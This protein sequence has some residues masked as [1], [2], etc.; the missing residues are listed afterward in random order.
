ME[1]K[2]EILNQLNSVL[3]QTDFCADLESM[4]LTPSQD[5]VI[6]KWKHGSNYRANVS[7]DSGIQMIQDVISRIRKK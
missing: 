5:W 7:C 2:Q 4:E 6:I 3:Q 1:N